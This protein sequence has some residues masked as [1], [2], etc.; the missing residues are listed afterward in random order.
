MHCALRSV[1]DFAALFRSG[2]RIMLNDRPSPTVLGPRSEPSLYMAEL[3]HR[4]GNEYAIAIALA[5]TASRK[6]STEAKAAL[7]TVIQHLAQ[8]GTVHRLLLPPA[9]EEGVDLGDYLARLCQTKL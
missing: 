1:V 6:S 7:E 2:S 4:V 9:V 5:S 8:L 3:L